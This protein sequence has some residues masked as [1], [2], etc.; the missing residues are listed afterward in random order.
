MAFCKIQLL[1]AIS[2]T[3]TTL[4]NRRVK[5]PTEGRRAN[6]LALANKIKRYSGKAGLKGRDI[7]VMHKIA[8]EADK[9]YPYSPTLPA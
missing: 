8:T 2:P 4:L 5:L 3:V 9:G 7:R 1:Q 6:R